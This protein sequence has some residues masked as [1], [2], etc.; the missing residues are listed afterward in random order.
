MS[1]SLHA[2]AYTE[3]HFAARAEELRWGMPLD[4]CLAC[5][6]PLSTQGLAKEEGVSCEVCH[7]PGMTRAVVRDVCNRCHGQATDNRDPSSVVLS[8]PLEF[9]PSLARREG[10]TCGS[11]HLPKQGDMTFHAFAGSRV[12]PES[13]AGT[14]SIQQV[15][16]RDGQLEVTL[17]NNVTGHW[18]PTGAETN[19]ILLEVTALDSRGQNAG[20]REYRFEKKTFFFRTMPMWVTGDTRLRDGELRKLAFQFPASAARVSAAVKIQPLLWDGQ[21][22]EFVIDQ[23]AVAVASP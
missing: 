8:T 6:S 16:V 5:H 18:L 1:G 21:F 13:Y 10:A 3:A 2:K 20:Q 7:G 12:A 9:E 17:K 4:R 11:C 15:E 23:K 14:I 19:V 22:G